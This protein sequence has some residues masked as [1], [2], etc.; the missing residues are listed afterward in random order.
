MLLFTPPPPPHYMRWTV[1]FLGAHD[2]ENSDGEV[3]TLVADDVVR[4]LT[5]FL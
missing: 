2:F 4:A 5:G 1:G 3:C